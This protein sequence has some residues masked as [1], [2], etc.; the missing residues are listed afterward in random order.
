M[1]RYL[2]EGHDTSK[3]YFTSNGHCE[4]CEIDV[5]GENCILWSYDT[6]K[7]IQ[8]TLQSLFDLIVNNGDNGGIIY[9]E[10][11]KVLQNELNF[12]L[13]MFDEFDKLLK[14]K[15]KLDKI[16]REYMW[17]RDILQYQLQGIRR[18]NKKGESNEN[19]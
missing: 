14:V 4:K 11:L 13:D 2:K 18:K 12:D 8:D 19:N 1:I 3:L 17:V 15:N 9:T 16:K 5:E 6:D 10:D 7:P